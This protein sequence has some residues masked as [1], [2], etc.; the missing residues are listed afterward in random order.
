[1]QLRL[2][3]LWERPRRVTVTYYAE[4]VLGTTRDTQQAHIM[5]EFV[6]EQNAL[7]ATNHFN[8]EFGGRVAFLAASKYPHNITTDRTEFLG[9][10]G[11]LRNA[12]R[13]WS[14][15]IGKRGQCWA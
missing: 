11:S 3:N 2:Q 13:S 15:W 9:R 1:M 5:P 10:M 6:P 12:C 8:S 14:H 7:I 4:W